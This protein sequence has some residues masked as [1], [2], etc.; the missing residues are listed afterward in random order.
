MCKET[1]Q[2][3]DFLKKVRQKVRRAGLDALLV[4]GEKDI[5]YLTGYSCAG[6]KLLITAK[7]RPSYFI[8]SM[9][10]SLARDMLEG[11][12]L[13]E[14][15]SG[16]PLKTLKKFV[17]NSNIRKI[18]I[19]EN[20]LS[21]REYMHLIGKVRALRPRDASSIMGDMRE[22]KHDHEIR[23]LKKAARE[24]IKIWREVKKNIQTGMSE[25]NIA[26]MVDICARSRGYE[27][28]FTTIAAAGKNTA[29]PHAVAGAKR[30]GPEE[31]LLLDF[32]IRLEGYC[33]DLTRTWDNGRID[34]QIRDFGEFVRRAQDLAIKEIKPG[35]IV[36]SIVGKVYNVFN[37][38]NLGDFVLHG[39][40]HGVGLDVHESPILHK[41][42]RQ[43][44]RQGM[45]LAIEPGLYKPGL[46]GVRKEDMVLVTAKGC[47]VLTV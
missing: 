40:G 16:S 33:S 30:L 18:G 6:A 12:E 1:T 36:G 13:R 28:S 34:R 2:R 4:S 3:N 24:T 7:E 32:G 46:G 15:I 10:E 9:N 44:L 38:N 17:G 25:R 14:I 19:N 26:A 45:V 27:N 47:E 5:L 21:A 20:G 41:E 42:C 37:E 23:I 22:K 35:V 29:Y 8:D 11:S 43:R 31:H 39:L